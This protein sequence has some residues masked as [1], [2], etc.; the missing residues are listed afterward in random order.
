MAGVRN[1]TQ[2]EAA[3]RA[4]LLEVTG[5]DITLDL[6]DGAG[7]P[8][9]STFHCVTE[10]TFRCAEPGAQTFI[11]VAAAGIRSASLNGAP[12]DTAGW[13][14][15]EGLSLVGLAA[16]NVLV[17]DADFRY[18]ASGQGLHRS[19]DPVDGE[20]YLYSQFETA[21]AQ[22][23]FACFDQPD[24]KS[25]FTWHATVPRH[26]N[27]VSNMPQSSV[28]LSPAGATWHFATSAVMSTY[29]TALCAGPYHYVGDSHDGIELGIY[30]R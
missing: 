21:D 15:E 17:V 1:L 26:W 8:G 19:V 18:S 27:V 16:E 24:L 22:R 5:Y 30:C 20:V 6:T 9:E 23:V 29:I 2:V 14:T 25:T 4:R 13:S 11:E 3:E 10:V 12:V 7:G 28:E